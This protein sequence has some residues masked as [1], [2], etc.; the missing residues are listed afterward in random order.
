MLSLEVSLSFPLSLFLPFSLPL[1]LPFSLPLISISF[2]QLSVTKDSHV[3]IPNLF[4]FMIQV[5]DLISVFVFS[6]ISDINYRSAL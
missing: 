3:I 5:K 1:S 2:I 6:H 4:N